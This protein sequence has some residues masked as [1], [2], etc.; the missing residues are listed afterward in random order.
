M[1][2]AC[3][4]LVFGKVATGDVAFWTSV[5]AIEEGAVN[6]FSVNGKC[7]SV[8]RLLDALGRDNGAMHCIDGLRDLR[9]IDASAFVQSAIYARNA[10]AVDVIWKENAFSG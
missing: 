2:F 7:K 9:V 5:D 3:F 4:P 6:L 8:V 1:V 10:D